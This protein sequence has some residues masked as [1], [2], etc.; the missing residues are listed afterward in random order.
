[1]VRKKNGKKKLKKKVLSSY[2]ISKTVRGSWHGVVPVTKV[3]QDERL[4]TTKRRQA[5][6]KLIQHTQE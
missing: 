4:D 6:K 3:E 1:M 5:E 2:E